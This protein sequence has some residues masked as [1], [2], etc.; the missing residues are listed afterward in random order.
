MHTKLVYR[1]VRRRWLIH[2]EVRSILN[3]HCRHRV[4]L[5]SNFKK[6]LFITLFIKSFWLNLKISDNRFNKNKRTFKFEMAA[7]ATMTASN[8]SKEIS[9]LIFVYRLC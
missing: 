7:E 9:A 2:D 3:K 5:F 6:K 4:L 8:D 1:V